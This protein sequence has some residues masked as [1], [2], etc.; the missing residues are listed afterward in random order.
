MKYNISNLDEFIYDKD[1][2]NSMIFEPTKGLVDKIL[3]NRE[4]LIEN[5]IKELIKPYVD[6]ENLNMLEIATILAGEDLEL[7]H[8]SHKECEE[9]CICKQI[10]KMIEQRDYFTVKYNVDLEKCES[11]IT[12][13]DIVRGIKHE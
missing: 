11:W 10:T 8:I 7:K 6:I 2:I 4:N 1:R 5:K 3:E 12:I 9:Y 13:S